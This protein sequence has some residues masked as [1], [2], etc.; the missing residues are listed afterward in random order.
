VSRERR[1]NPK[2][3]GG[4]VPDT[5]DAKSA[6]ST[7]LKMI[8]ITRAASF[9]HLVGAR[10]QSRR[11]G[12]ARIYRGQGPPGHPVQRACRGRWPDRLRSCLLARPRRHCV[13][14]QG[15]R[16]S[17]RP[18]TRLAQDEEPGCTSGDTRSGGGLGEMT[19]RKREIVGP[20]N[21]RDFPYLVELA[22]TSQGLRATLRSEPGAYPP[23]D[24]VD[25]PAQRSRCG[26]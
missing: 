3:L 9:D 25:R 10:E 18:L 21:E 15:L 23:A 22:G 26:T 6:D 13:E 12:H 20:R 4:T 1:M 5:F 16:L 24:R 17:F 8:R 11:H 19:R 7:G 2:C 14:A